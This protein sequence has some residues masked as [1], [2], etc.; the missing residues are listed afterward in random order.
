M[1]ITNI[2]KLVPITS[3]PIFDAELEVEGG[4]IKWF[5]PSS[6]PP[7][8]R[9]RGRLQRESRDIFDCKG[10]VVTPGLVDCHTHLVHAGTRE[11]E[12]AM[13]AAGK[14]YLEIA[15]AGGGILSTVAATRET[16]FDELY[17]LSERRLKEAISFGTT[18]IEI[19][20]GYGLDTE[21][22]IKILKVA[23]K[24]AKDFPITIVGTFLGAHTFPPPLPSREGAR[25]RGKYID[26]LISE[27]LPE[28]AKLNFVR[29]CD[30]FVEKEAFTVAEA[31]QILTA[32]KKFKMG[33]KLH[34]DQLSA[35]KGAE[36]A[37]ELKAV[38]ADH[39]E[40]ISEEGIGALKKSGT[41]AVLLPG[42]SFFL[43]MKPAPARALLDRGV[44]VAIA[45]D[46]NPGTNPC[47]NLPLMGTLAMSQL[48]M[49]ADEVWQAMTIHAARAL[50]LEKEKGSIEIGK[51]ADLILWE[52][53][54]EIV[55]LYRYGSDC[56]RHIFA[57]GKQ[58]L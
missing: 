2:K 43:G 57:K 54:D 15:K 56:I 30:V 48:K 32:A 51:D 52:A 6:F 5:G 27:M 17:A 24:L 55:P 23:Q 38:S 13:R 26:L 34:V 50:N 58:L 44:L 14:S 19:K 16:T 42:A 11:K 33:I 53:A 22:E 18:T 31:I 40:H 12:F 28:A 45:T 8:V 47:L 46:Y 29:F 9:V 4:K 20:S 35:G 37:A 36:L 49:K 1:L 41:V 10:A 3:E 39:L 25:G 21:T 7:R